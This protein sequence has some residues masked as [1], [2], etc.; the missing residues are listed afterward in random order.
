MNGKWIVT[1]ADGRTFTG[2][3]ASIVRQMRDNNWMQMPNKRGYAEEVMDRVT[4]VTGKKPEATYEEMGARGFLAYL[5]QAEMVSM[6]PITSA[7]GGDSSL[8]PS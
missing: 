7:M 6:E 8:T 5:E 3:P 1:T 4:Q 2:T